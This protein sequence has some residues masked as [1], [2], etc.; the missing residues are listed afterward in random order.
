MVYIPFV[1]EANIALFA[2]ES[3]HQKQQLQI[4]SAS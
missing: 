2:Y 3:T 1:E 4:W